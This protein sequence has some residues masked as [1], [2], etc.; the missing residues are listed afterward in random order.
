M[1]TKILWQNGE[2]IE[3]DLNPIRAIRAKCMQCGNY[4]T[5]EIEK[6]PCEDCALWHFRLGKNPD[7]KPLSEE[8]INALRERAKTSGFGA[9]H[10][11]TSSPGDDRP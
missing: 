5:K 9:R 2:Q 10:G 8:R 4:Q 6:C 1:K 11:N 7:R 3:K